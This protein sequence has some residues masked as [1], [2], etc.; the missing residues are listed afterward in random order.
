MKKYIE[1][2]KMRSEF[3]GKS[4]NSEYLLKCLKKCR[5]IDEK[6]FSNAS[7][8]METKSRIQK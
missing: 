4:K 2:M 8:N 3:G 7:K 5:N 6:I 1:M